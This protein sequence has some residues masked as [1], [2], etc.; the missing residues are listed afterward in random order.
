MCIRDSLLPPS[1]PPSSSLPPPPSLPLWLCNYHAFVCGQPITMPLF[2]LSTSPLLLSQL[3]AG[4][5]S[6]RS[7]IKGLGS[8][9][10][11][12]S[13]NGPDSERLPTAHT[14]FNHLLLP[15]Y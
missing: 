2:L 1:L 4:T 6:D 11:V 9:T 10:F 8:M 12:I 5:G 15:E 7:P 3:V 13:R 14:C